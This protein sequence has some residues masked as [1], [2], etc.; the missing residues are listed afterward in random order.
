MKLEKLAIGAWRID[1]NKIE[2]L[3]R[4]DEEGYSYF[5]FFYESQ[6]RSVYQTKVKIKNDNKFL[7]ELGF[8]I[9]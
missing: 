4:D 2:S 8:K 6:L 5:Y 3:Q 1:R 9:S 7:P